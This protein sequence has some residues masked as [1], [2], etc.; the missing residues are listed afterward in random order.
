MEK[1]GEG[2]RR[3]EEWMGDPRTNQ[4]KN[5]QDDGKG[6]KGTRKDEVREELRHDS[7]AKKDGAENFEGISFAVIAFVASEDARAGGKVV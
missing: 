1:E 3:M 4:I 6:E 2:R 5:C 7:R